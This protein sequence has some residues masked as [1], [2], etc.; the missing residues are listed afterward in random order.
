MLDLAAIKPTSRA[1]DAPPQSDKKPVNGRSENPPEQ[2]FQSAY[3]SASENTKETQKHSETMGQG[4]KTGPEPSEEQSKS[5][6]PTADEADVLVAA[7]EGQAKVQDVSEN[8]KGDSAVGLKSDAK[9]GRNRIDNS[10]SATGNGPPSTKQSGGSEA[11]DKAAAPT[12]AG[13]EGAALSSKEAG[14]KTP[15]E[16]I[17]LSKAAETSRR[18][19]AEATSEPRTG[20]T[21]AETVKQQPTAQS[22]ANTAKA[23]IKQSAANKDDAQVRDVELRPVNSKSKAPTP[24]VTPV[25]AT[26]LIARSQILSVTE[27]Q[28]DK[29]DLTPVV[30]SD[31]DGIGSWDTRTSSQV[32]STALGQV[33]NRPETPSLIARQMAEAL[34]KLPDR[35]VEISLNPKELGR[36]RMNISAVEAGITVSIVAER[37]ETLDLMRRHIEQ[38]TRE[39][40]SIGYENIAFAF[41]EGEE[42]SAY[43][44]QQSD[45]G[46]SEPSRLMIA[47]EDG[48]E[49]LQPMTSA[50]SGI[51][52]RL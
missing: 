23:E 47:E 16:A 13:S 26:P 7:G 48:V 3:E 24:T 35:P 8:A 20:V 22:V 52:I 5:D 27:A 15:A 37:P 36:V 21:S 30:T 6:K 40:Q 43:S 12:T 31:G 45:D 32:S 10:L 14:R 9:S 18:P 1:A 50:S 25:Q 46:Q 49:T 19:T 28:K 44:E 41:A 2:E 4:P 17:V 42:N 51:D 39:F 33:L 34:Q 38:L 29:S 11:S